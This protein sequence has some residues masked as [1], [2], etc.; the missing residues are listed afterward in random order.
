MFVSFDKAKERYAIC[1]GCEFFGSVTRSCS[2]CGC[3]MPAKVCI[4]VA[5]C[6]LRKWGKETKKQQD[7]KDYNVEG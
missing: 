5:E 2:E 6:P 3:F 4:T 7:K 1:K